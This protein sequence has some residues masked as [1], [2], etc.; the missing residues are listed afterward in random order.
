M[1]PASIAEILSAQD[2]FGDASSSLGETNRNL[3]DLWPL[4]SGLVSEPSDVEENSEPMHSRAGM[5]R[6]NTLPVSFVARPDDGN[7]AP[8][9]VASPNQLRTS[10]AAIAIQEIKPHFSFEGTPTS[11]TEDRQADSVTVQTDANHVRTTLTSSTRSADENETVEEPDSDEL[12][13]ESSTQESLSESTNNRRKSDSRDTSKLTWPQPEALIEQIEAVQDIEAT[14]AWAGD[15]LKLIDMLSRADSLTDPVSKA[16]FGQ[17]ENQRLLLERLTVTVSTVPAKDSHSAQGPLV[18][19][20]LRLDYSLARRLALWRLV[21]QLAVEQDSMLVDGGQRAKMIQVSKRKISFD[22][23]PNWR[24]Y[25]LIDEANSILNS[26]N[27]NELEQK[28]MAR[29]VLARMNSPALT[30]PQ[31]QFALSALEP[32][33]YQL[34]KA[35]A[36]STP[37]LHALLTYVEKQELDGSGFTQYKV[38]DQYQHLLWSDNRVAQRLA[39]ELN[40]HYRNA[41]FRVSVSEQFVNRLIPEM[42]ATAEPISERIM[43]AQVFG[44]NHIQNR[45]GI[46][47]I[48]DPSH[49]Q[50]QIVT[51]GE[52]LSNTR[53]SKSG[54]TIENRGTARFHAFKRLAFG[55]NG[56]SSDEPV[57]A[58][59]ADQQVVGMSSRLDPIPL[60]GWVARRIARQKIEEEKPRAE[61]MVRQRVE[62]TV[63]QRMQ[64]EV[65]TQLNQLRAYLDQNIYQP[66]VAMDLEPDAVEM[67]T[68]SDRLVMRYRLA[69]RDQMG[70]N[71]ARPRATSDS[72]LSMQIHESAIN[73]LL[74]RIELGGRTFTAPELIEHLEQRIGASMSHRDEI[75]HEAEF[76]FAH[77]DPIRVD[78]DHDRVQFSIN[79]KSFKVGEKGKTWRNLTA[80]TTYVPQ[81]QGRKIV[82]V[83]DQGEMKLQGKGLKLRDQIAIRTIFEALFDES[84]TMAVLPAS[85]IERIESPELH[86]NQLVVENGWIGVSISEPAAARDAQQA[87]R[88]LL[89]RRR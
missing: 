21:Q 67:S 62:S 16:I 60:V 2:P 42:P 12:E 74:M 50:M 11:T 70:A 28:R 53:A 52:V 38:N 4:T 77:F 6:N 31:R 41:N 25:L 56:V 64:Q 82:L 10:Q 43:G 7:F 75:E 69:G 22:V 46:E 23:H 49:I 48:P 39:G 78:F 84:Y 68:S 44:Q 33:L 13:T 19:E 20:L 72:L 85:L 51:V 81:V 36:T 80:S 87:G 58:S 34:L 55:R 8:Q 17:L 63:S 30:M 79:L 47:F 65:E 57:A 27:P 32:E 14:R 24:E 29:K 18:T 54:F 40:T 83:Q 86:I 37:D 35:K 59:S 89:R 73:N 61:Q 15:T 5:H 76:E 26:L 66:L 45:M 88:G 9:T 3:D 71:T 1:L